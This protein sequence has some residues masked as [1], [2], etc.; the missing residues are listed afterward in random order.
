MKLTSKNENY[1]KKYIQ[2]YISLP[3]KNRNEKQDILARC[4]ITAP[5]I[6]QPSHIRIETSDRSLPRPYFSPRKINHVSSVYF[7]LW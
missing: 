5:V 1:W 4:A 3:V 7:F 6:G 2:L